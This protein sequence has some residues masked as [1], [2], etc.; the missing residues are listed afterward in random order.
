MLGKRDSEIAVVIEVCVR[1]MWLV[2]Q[3]FAKNIAVLCMRSHEQGCD[4][5]IELVHCCPDILSVIH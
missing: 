3:E 5:H 2:R 4:A 1:F